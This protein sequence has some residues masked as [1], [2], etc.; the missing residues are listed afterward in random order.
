MPAGIC[1][2]FILLFHSAMQRNVWIFSPLH[3]VFISSHFKAR[4]NREP[5]VNRMYNVDETRVW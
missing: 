1:F 5:F 2:H 4:F 3:L